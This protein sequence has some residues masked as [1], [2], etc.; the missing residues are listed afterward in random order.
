MEVIGFLFFAFVS[1]KLF[2]WILSIL[3]PRYGLRKAMA[4]HPDRPTER[5]FQAVL[6]AQERLSRR[7]G[8]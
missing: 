1:W 6:R 2:F 7:M 8:H 5:N 4:R 3:F